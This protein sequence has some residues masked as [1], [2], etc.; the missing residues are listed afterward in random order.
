MA[1]VGTVAG[2]WE[3]RTFERFWIVE[4]VSRT[5]GSDEVECCCTVGTKNALRPG[6]DFF[7]G[8]TSVELSSVDGGG[9]T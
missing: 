8:A 4:T 5:A 6:S 7:T 3:V 2:L 1:L 9:A